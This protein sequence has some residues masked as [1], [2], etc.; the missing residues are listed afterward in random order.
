MEKKISIAEK[1]HSSELLTQVWF[2]WRDRTDDPDRA[3]SLNQFLDAYVSAGGG[4]EVVCQA[5]ALENPRNSISREVVNNLRGDGWYGSRV[6]DQVVLRVNPRRRGEGRELRSYAAFRV[7][8]DS[9]E[10]P[11]VVLTRQ[12][13]AY[14]FLSA[15]AIDSF[16]LI[17]PSGV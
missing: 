8:V 2:N 7:V 16:R 4:V 14:D 9:R 1:P 17:R 13:G 5:A 6:D 12:S 3:A 11:V 10:G 15:F